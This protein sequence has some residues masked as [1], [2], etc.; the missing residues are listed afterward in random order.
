MNPIMNKSTLSLLG[1]KLNETIF[2][3]NVQGAASM[4][5]IKRHHTTC[6][7]KSTEKTGLPKQAANMRTSCTSSD[8]IVFIR[9]ATKF[10]ILTLVLVR[11][12]RNNWVIL[13]DENDDD[14]VEVE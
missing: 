7:N 8:K 10:S 3:G 13:L 1:R 2:L 12:F 9:V 4:I 11:R 5:R 6:C 14:T